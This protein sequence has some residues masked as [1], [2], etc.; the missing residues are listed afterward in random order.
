M[1]LRL[2]DKINNESRADFAISFLK[3]ERKIKQKRLKILELGTGHG[4]LYKKLLDDGFEVYGLD[5]IIPKEIRKYKI[6][7]WDLNKGLPFNKNQFDAVI[8]L[9]VLEHLYNPFEMMK[10]I[11]RVLKIN[12][13]AIISMPNTDSIFS[14]VGQLYEKRM[15]N[16]DPYWH[17]YQP[18][19]I[20]IR[21][22][23]ETTL[24]INGE[25]FIF[26]F[27]TFSGFDWLGKIFLRIS[28]YKFAG[29]YMVFAKKLN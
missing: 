6:K 25:K 5:V 20:S 1:R 23:V 27:R 18:S 9:E 15:D 22:L 10:E 3:K 24:K 2:K 17:H 12:G 4:E 28:P 7:K 13:M 21:N 19:I 26:S 29:D 11:H 8:A 14:R 16:L